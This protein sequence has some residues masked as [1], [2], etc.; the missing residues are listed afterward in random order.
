MA[1]L[2]AN[3]N[4][5]PIRNKAMSMGKG[6]DNLHNA[7]V[8]GIDI[9]EIQCDEIWS[10]VQK[11]QARVTDKEFGDAY[12][13]MALSRTKKLIVS[14]RVGKRDEAQTKAFIADLRARLVTIPEISTDGWQSYPVAV[15]QSFAGSA[16]HAILQKNYS[17]KGRADG[18][19]HDHRY[20]PPRDPFITK[21]VAH[22]VPD[23]SRATTSH[24]E[25]L[26]LATRMHIRRFTRRCNGFS[27]KLENHRAAVSLHVAWYNFCRVHESL[28]VTP[29]MDAGITDHVW[30]I[31]E[32]VTRALTAEP[33][34]APEPKPLAPPAPPPGE[35]PVTAKELPNGKGWLRVVQGGKSAKKDAP[36]APTPPMTPAPVVAKMVEA[37]AAPK[38]W[39]QLDLFSWQPSGRN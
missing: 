28:R 26:N 8:H 7:L 6:C 9:R 3:R 2:L 19:R 5:T 20:E 14:Y 23:L 4:S 18:P 13:Y 15:G 16:D 25:R 27:K 35:K 11:K 38:R 22:G 34:A 10:Y 31:E 32:L 36:K 1:L 21:Q 29:A 24:V 39:E 12:T 17:R 33:C 30:S 37:L